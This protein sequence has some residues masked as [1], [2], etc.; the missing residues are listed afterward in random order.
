MAVPTR[1]ELAQLA[2]SG[3]FVDRVT[4][5]VSFFARYIL[6][7]DPATSNHT[8]R[9][10]WAKRAYRN[11]KQEAFNLMESIALDSA[12]ANQD[13]LDFA[14]TPDTGAGSVQ[15]AVEATLAR[16]LKF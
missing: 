15:A 16:I 6:D 13:P 7:E 5:A 1:Y 2:K 14:N 9:Y 3:A 12:F 4:M 11:P 8:V 10:E